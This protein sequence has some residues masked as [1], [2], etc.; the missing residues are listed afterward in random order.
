[1]KKILL[2]KLIMI[3]CLAVSAQATL[4]LPDTYNHL[5]IGKYPAF[6][7]VD[8]EDIER[9]VAVYKTSVKDGLAS[10]AVLLST[11]RS[12]SGPS[13]AW[14]FTGNKSLI[15]AA[16]APNDP[17]FSSTAK[18]SFVEERGFWSS[19]YSLNN[20]QQIPTIV[21]FSRVSEMPEPASLFIL[22][23]GLLVMA[24][25]LKKRTINNKPEEEME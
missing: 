15:Y 14:T 22:G 17:G 13:T 23:V 8:K 6:S 21:N 16:N 20:G 19:R 3:L 25:F 24:R 2:L 10:N 5:K 11:R 12:E 18:T 7:Y 9:S 1:V 4:F